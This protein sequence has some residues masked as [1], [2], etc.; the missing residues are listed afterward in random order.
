L[1]ARLIAARS[2][3]I[4]RRRTPTIPRWL[5]GRPVNARNANEVEREWLYRVLVEKYGVS[6]EAADGFGRARERR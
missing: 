2:A 5:L 1:P 3:P 6:A 4:Y